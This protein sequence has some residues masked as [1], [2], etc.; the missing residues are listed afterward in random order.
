MSITLFKMD[1]K[2]YWRLILVFFL[3]L[4]LY[5]SVIVAI[6]DPSG[7]SAL[8]GMMDQLPEG[9][10]NAFGMGNAPGS[11]TANLA[12]FFFGF[13][14]YIFPTILSIMLA[15]GLVA[16]HADRGSMACLLATPNTR[17]AIARTQAAFLIFSMTLTF[18]LLLPCGILVCE[19]FFP[20][21]L[22]IQQFILMIFGVYL[23][24]FAISGICFL[25]SCAAKDAK[26]SLAFGAGIPVAF[27]LLK[28][29]GQMGGSISW[30]AD[31]SLYSMISPVQ[32]ALGGSLP[33]L[34]CILLTA[35]GVLCF[36]IG[37]LIFQKKDFSV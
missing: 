30:M 17:G 20:G 8:Q 34:A 6:F 28:M 2:S 25:C 1:F 11:F 24:L 15:H 4:M 36:S 21:S 37:I 16:K 9:M 3:V 33:I 5:F 14:I 22:E 31:V 32:I 12:N 23:T 35:I 29:L 13:I 19:A 10:V 7:I 26:S 27:F 18:L